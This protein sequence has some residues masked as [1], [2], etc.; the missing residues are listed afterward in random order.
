MYLDADSLNHYMQDKLPDYLK[1]HFWDIQFISRM[2]DGMAYVRVD[3][4]ITNYVN[5]KSATLKFKQGA[6]DTLVFSMKDATVDITPT[7]Q[8]FGMGM[9]PTWVK[10]LILYHFN[11]NIEFKI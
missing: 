10:H 2:M 11:L 7:G 4:F 1:G 3:N 8:V 6:K 5:Y 9:S